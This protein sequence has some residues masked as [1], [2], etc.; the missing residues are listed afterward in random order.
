MAGCVKRGKPSI[1]LLLS[2]QV[3]DRQVLHISIPQHC[4]L[5][6]NK[7][8]SCAP[9]PPTF[10]SISSRKEMSWISTVYLQLCSF[11]TASLFMLLLTP[12]TDHLLGEET[13]LPRRSVC[14]LFT[15][16]ES[17]YTNTMSELSTTKPCFSDS[18]FVRGT[19]STPR[20][21]RVISATKDSPDHRTYRFWKCEPTPAF[22]FSTSE[23]W[24]STGNK[25]TSRPLQ[26]GTVTGST[27]PEA[28]RP[29]WVAPSCEG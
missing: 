27:R 7:Q 24:P 13:A 20:L 28:S 12:K 1:P 11:D 29:H 15:T 21:K 19:L 16:A 18:I 6:S 22:R 9:P 4:F 17:G 26:S 25:P 8:Q 2:L 23:A 5:L 14:S 3:S 10:S